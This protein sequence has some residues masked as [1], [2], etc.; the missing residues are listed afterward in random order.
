LAAV[1]A[2]GVPAGVVGASVGA[3]PVA[4]GG[5]WL[6]ESAGWLGVPVAPVGPALGVPAD[7]EPAGADAEA[8]CDAG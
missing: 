3:L 4:V 5:G 7:G 8:G 2:P 6:G 1:V